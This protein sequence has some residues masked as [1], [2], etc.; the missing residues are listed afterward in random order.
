MDV[1][2]SNDTKTRRLAGL[3]CRLASKEQELNDKHLKLRQSQMEVERG[4]KVFKKNY[5]MKRRE[6][7]GMPNERMQR[8]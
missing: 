3:E 7:K 1:R 5:L 6:F 8:K 4:I 2:Q